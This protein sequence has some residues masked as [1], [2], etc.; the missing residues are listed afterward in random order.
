VPMY[1]AGAWGPKES[2]QLLER[3]GRQWYNP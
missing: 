3:D 2:D 1:P